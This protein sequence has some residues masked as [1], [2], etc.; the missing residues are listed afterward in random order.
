MGLLTE[1]NALSA[2]E[3]LA[4]SKY[5]RDH[6]ITQFLATWNRVKDI[7]DDELRFGDEI[8]VGILKVDPKTKTVRICVRSA[9]LK[10]QLELKEDRVAHQSEGV[11][12][13]PEFGA[14]M[15]E[16]TPSRPYVRRNFNLPHNSAFL[17]LSPFCVHTTA[18]DS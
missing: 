10:A 9:K 12:W 17:N 18:A 5:I 3:T 2:E 13:H 14:W 4:L 16:S 6:G 1:G 11:T 15:I 8:E 7:Q